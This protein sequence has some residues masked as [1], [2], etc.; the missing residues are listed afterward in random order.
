MSTDSRIT[1]GLRINEVIRSHPETVAVFHELGLDA[2]C[3]GD[4]T[5][6]EASAAHGL[7]VDA[8]LEALE[9]RAAGIPL[10]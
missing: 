8:V 7:S 1:P 5:L 10:T 6:A 3:G 4:R 9:E 2:C